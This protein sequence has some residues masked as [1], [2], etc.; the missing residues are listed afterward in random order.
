MQEITF[1]ER[2][3]GGINAPGCIDI[4]HDAFINNK[5]G[6]IAELFVPSFIST[7][8][9]MKKSLKI[10]RFILILFVVYFVLY[11]CQNTDRQKPNVII[12]LT[13]D[14]GYGDIGFNGNKLIH[15]PNMD[16]L[17][18]ESVRLNNFHVSPTCSPTRAALLTGRYNFRTGVWHTVTGRSNIREDEV[19]MAQVFAQNGYATGMFGK[20]HLGDDY[21]MRPMDKGF[22]TAVYL[23]GGTIANMNDYWNNDC[24]DD[25][26]RVNGEYTPFKGYCTDIFFKEAMNFIKKHR[27]SPFFVYLATKAAHWP[28]NVKDFYS[29][30]YKG[31]DRIPSPNFYGMITNVDE[32]LGKL[33]EELERLGVARNTIIVF[34]GDNGT[35]EGIRLGPG[36]YPTDC[37]FN[38]G[39]RGKKGSPYEGGHRVFCF[40]HWPAGGIIQGKDIDGLTAHFDIFPT[41]INMCNLTFTPKKP[42]DGINLYPYLRGG[43]WDKDRVIIVESERKE[44]PEKWRRSAVMAG[45]W[46]LINGVE[47]YNLDKDPGQKKDIAQLY[48]DVV[49]KLRKDYTVWYKDVFSNWETPSYIVLGTHHEENPILTSHDWLGC[50]RPD[51]SPAVN[52]AN[53]E[54]PPWHQVHA[55]RGTQINGYW[56]I[57]IKTQGLYEFELRRWPREL[58]LEIC[59][60]CPASGTP[61]GGEPYPPGIFLKIESATIQVGNQTKSLP[62]TTKDKAIT[63]RVNLPKGKTQ[64]KTWFRGKNISLGAYYVYVNK[65]Q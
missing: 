47:L 12:L 40:I 20:W 54:T 15:T 30:P 19:T 32:N 49:K 65:I 55:R 58:D 6:Q 63:F 36:G 13:D 48:P 46:R 39:M 62:V 17:A 35:S 25:H 42:L 1:G 52:G 28:D 2:N 33:R 10:I 41:L 5:R 34:M 9:T 21:P 45:K 7:I 3:C 31:N 37:G 16:I 38:A 44:K 14:Q 51:G 26:Y 53:E 64:L 57:Y 4:Y 23:G 8:K 56:N 24:F 22:Q 59:K 50:V 60:G 11:G 29:N 27:G 18:K 43:K 61:P